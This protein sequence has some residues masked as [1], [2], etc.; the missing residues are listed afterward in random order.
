[1]VPVTRLKSVN[2]LSNIQD[3][4]WNSVFWSLDERVSS[5]VDIRIFCPTILGNYLD[6]C[7]YFIYICI[8]FS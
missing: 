3:I 2:F 7:N 1:M 6:I 5:G 8:L 4:Y